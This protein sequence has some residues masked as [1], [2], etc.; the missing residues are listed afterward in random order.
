MVSYIG[1]PRARPVQ[2]WVHAIADLGTAR[3]DAYLPICLAEMRRKMN[4]RHA[5]D[6]PD[7]LFRTLKHLADTCRDAVGPDDA[8]FF[9]AGPELF[10]SA[11]CLG[12][13][14]NPPSFPVK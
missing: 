7:L 14:H 12:F 4:Y 11:I 2:A 9:T 8:G 3:G 13:V 1:T 10:G 6:A 5:R